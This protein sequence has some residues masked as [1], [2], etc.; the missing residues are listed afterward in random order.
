MLLLDPSTGLINN[1]LRSMPFL[2]GLNFDIYSFWGIIWAH[3]M[4]N[5][6]STKVMI[7]TPAFRRMDASM[8]EASRMSGASS[9]TTML[10]ITVPAM[11]PVIIVVFCSV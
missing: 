5:G 9:L 7:M 11:T 1:W 6:I 3:V 2:S 4:A 8:E 10:R